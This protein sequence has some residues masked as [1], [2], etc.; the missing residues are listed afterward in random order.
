MYSMNRERKSRIQGVFLTGVAVL[1]LG[2]V[3]L[4]TSAFAQGSEKTYRVTIIN[5]TPNNGG[6][7][8]QV[9]SPPLIVAHTNKVDVFT[10]G[11]PASPGVAEMAEDANASTAISMLSSNPNVSF[12]GRPGGAI[13]PGQ[14]ASYE[15]TTRTNAKLLSLVTMLV[16]T[17]DAFAGLDAVRLSGNESE[18][19]V[20]AYDAGSEQ[21]DQ[22]TGNIPGPCCGDT[23]ANGTDEFGV[24][25]HHPGIL[26]GVGD[27]DPAIWGWNTSQ[28][29]AKIKV[30][31]V[32]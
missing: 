5:L 1:A 19:Y 11:A 15:F 14:S 17:N 27:L 7:A 29:V 22:L 9:L 20:L 12:V 16:S 30:E 4:S 32:R 3:S 23:G 10:V 26:S 18:F 28:P 13:P 21:N 6:G 25:T 24:I 2:L 8:S 31:R